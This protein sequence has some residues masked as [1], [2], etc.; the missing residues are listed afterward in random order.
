MAVGTPV[1]AT[2]AGG[3]PEI[4]DP[5]GEARDVGAGVR[6]APYGLLVTPGDPAAL[7]A[8]VAR[9]LDDP[10]AAADTARRAR[11]HARENFTIERTWATVAEVWSAAAR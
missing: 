7:A 3:A 4:V 9:V 5:R 2:D 11:E 1:I 10:D 8:A 6:Q